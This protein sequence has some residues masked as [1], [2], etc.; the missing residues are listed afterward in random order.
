MW[1]L[2]FDKARVHPGPV[3]PARRAHDLR[4]IARSARKLR[5]N[6]GDEGW[7]AL[8]DGYGAD[9]PDGLVLR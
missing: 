7:Q 8:R 4:R 9:W 2:D 3:P 5:V 1:L 6:V